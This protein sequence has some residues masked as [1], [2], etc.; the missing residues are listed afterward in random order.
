[1]LACLC[2]ICVASSNVFIKY[3]ILNGISKG[4]KYPT[5]YSNINELTIQTVCNTISV[6]LS[7]HHNEAHKEYMNI[8]V[9]MIWLSLYLQYR[10]NNY[11]NCIYPEL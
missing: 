1:M 3:L 4:I 5:V 2:I 7:L 6:T 9:K 11:A 10:K 8:N